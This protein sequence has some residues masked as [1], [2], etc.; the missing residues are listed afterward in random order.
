MTR[1]RA[2]RV[3]V[4][5]KIGDSGVELLRE[6]F[7]VDVGSAGIASRAGASGSATTRGS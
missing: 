7:D 5:E 4:A 3:L 6:H 1:H 2:T